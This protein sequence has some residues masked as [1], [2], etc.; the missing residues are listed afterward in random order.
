MPEPKP[1]R[2]TQIGHGPRIYSHSPQQFKKWGESCR[3]AG[4]AAGYARG[5]KEAERDAESRQLFVARLRNMQTDEPDVS[6]AYVLAL[7]D[8]CDMLAARDRDS[9]LLMEVKP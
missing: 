5:L 8:D 9:A 1:D 7:L 3:A 6:V 4:E 2:V